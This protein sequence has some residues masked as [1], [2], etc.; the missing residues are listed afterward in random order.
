M[1]QQSDAR[2]DGVQQET[3]SRIDRVFWGM[4]GASVI[5]GGGI[6]AALFTVAL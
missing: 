5:V 3:S 4:I 1:Q 2:I 6:I